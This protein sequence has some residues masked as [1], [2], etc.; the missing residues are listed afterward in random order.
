MEQS[1]LE[2]RARSGCSRLPCVVGL[3]SAHCQQSIR[4][5]FQRIAYEELQLAC[6][7]ATAGKPRQIVPLDPKF[8]AINVLAKIGQTMNRRRQLR[9]REV[10]QLVQL[11]P[12]LRDR[13]RGVCQASYPVH[14]RFSLDRLSCGIP[15]S[16]YRSWLNTHETS[17]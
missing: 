1:A 11:L 12:D 15:R 13:P 16:K 5:R 9:Q 4:S 7:V 17:G 2:A 8:G 14:P 6:L 10:R 3:N